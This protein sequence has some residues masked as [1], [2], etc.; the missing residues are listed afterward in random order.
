L[1][2]AGIDA[3]E[4]RN[5]GTKL[6]PAPPIGTGPTG[7]IAVGT[8]LDKYTSDQACRSELGR[9]SALDHQLVFQELIKLANLKNVV[10]YPVN[11]GGLEALDTNISQTMVPIEKD[12][13]R[14][15]DRIE[16]VMTLA[17]ATDG[18]A[19]VGTND[20]RAGLARIVN[21]VSAYY[22]LGYYSTNSKQDGR[23]RQIKVSVKQDKVAVAARRG[24]VAAIPASAATRTLEAGN[25]VAPAE[26]T[27]SLG[28]LAR[29]GTSDLFTY[30]IVSG[31]DVVVV[32]EIA[33]GDVELG[34][35]KGG[36]TVKV[37]VSDPSGKEVGAVTSR[38]EAGARG[39][40]MRVPYGSSAGPWKV[41]VTVSGADGSL[42]ERLDVRVG[43]HRLLGDPILYRSTGV[44]RTAVLRPVA[45][46]L[47]R[48]TERVH[49]EWPMFKPLDRRTARL[50]DRRGQPIPVEASLT[51]RT[52]DGQ[53]VLA[54]DLNL[55]Q[56]S[57]GDYVLEVSAVSG[58]ETQKRQVALRVVR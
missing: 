8:T 55:S 40:L 29:I 54:A 25:V 39:V 58:A 19:V 30:G 7:R 36:G 17:N 35:W 37:V 44:A 2:E 27:E 57:P 56:L 15:Q 42:D 20:L 52:D 23:F 3:L 6:S 32:A 51:E 11:P 49:I 22:L 38:I 45:E 21:D 33:S 13:A 12:M 48:R 53:V 46:F 24:Y 28:P 31:K 1:T 4:H 34:K 47:Y 43:T 5:P 10:I 41:A 18:I 14:R 9:L 16:S 50:L 26:V